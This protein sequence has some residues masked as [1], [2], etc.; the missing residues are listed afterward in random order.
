[1]ICDRTIFYPEGG[2]QLGDTGAIVAGGK[3]LRVRDTQIGDDGVIVHLLEAPLDAPLSGEA[4]LEIDV[5]RRRDHTAHHTAQHALSR[6]LLDACRAPTVSARLGASACTIDVDR[7]GIPD[8]ELARAED[9]VNDLVRADV[10]VR[11]FFP[12]DAELAKLDLRRA[13]KVDR[14]V[15]IVQIEGFD[16]TPCGGTHVSRTGEIGQVRLTGLEKYKG[17]LRVSFA[18][19]ARAL[20]DA[21]RKDEILAAITRALTCGLDAAPGALAKLVADLEARGMALGRARAELAALVADA[22]LAATPPDPSGTTLID[23]R[24]DADDV[25]TL[26][27]LAGRLTARPDVVAIC[28]APDGDAELV[29]VQRG[30]S[31][32]FDCAAWLES[33]I[34]ARGGRGGG[35]QERAEGRLPR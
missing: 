7:P 15:R 33:Q 11:A 16:L 35:R 19:A 5:A 31:A 10:P 26:R 6:A 18:A 23:L 2:G 1:M 22:R 32:S 8:A 25:A 14:G 12:D 4:R 9:L 30:A 28:R 27:V 13:P 34:S 24:R 3:S 20:A 17:K 21:R 29:V